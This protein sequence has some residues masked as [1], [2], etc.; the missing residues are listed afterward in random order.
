MDLLDGPDRFRVCRYGY[1]DQTIN[2]IFGAEQVNLRQN[3]EVKAR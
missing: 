2:V 1:T 3:K